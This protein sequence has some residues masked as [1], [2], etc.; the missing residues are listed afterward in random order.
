MV[1]NKHNA[2]RVTT[3]RRLGGDATLSIW[4]SRVTGRW[5]LCRRHQLP[6]P[7]G[8]PAGGGTVGGAPGVAA[9]KTDPPLGSCPHR[10]HTVP[11]ICPQ[12]QLTHVSYRDA[13]VQLRAAFDPTT[14]V[15]GNCAGIT[16]ATAAASRGSPPRR[17]AGSRASN[18]GYRAGF[19]LSL[20]S[21]Q[22]R[23]PRTADGH[24][25]P[26]FRLRAPRH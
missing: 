20:R 18:C 26:L 23:V 6:V 11:T 9:V 14:S 15:A 1:G 12:L 10:A 22:S 13:F 7:P 3:H 17:C 16:A 25:L 21:P 4:K 5:R 24:E 8:R 2:I 19:S